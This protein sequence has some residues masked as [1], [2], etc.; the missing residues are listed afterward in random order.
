[1][2]HQKVPSTTEEATLVNFQGIFSLDGKIALV[3]GGTRGL[4]F[5]AAS[6]YVNHLAK[7]KM[8]ATYN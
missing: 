7:R 1:M 4:G 3:T 5:Y 2:S 6:G 8:S